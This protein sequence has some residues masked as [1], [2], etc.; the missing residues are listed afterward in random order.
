MATSQENPLDNFFE[1][2]LL[3]ISMNTLN[4]LPWV[5]N[6]SEKEVETMKNKA[7]KVQEWYSENSIIPSWYDETWIEN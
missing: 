1:L 2:L 4:A 7:K 6:Y 3:Y 5:Q